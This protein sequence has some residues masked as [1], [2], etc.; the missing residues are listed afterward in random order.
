M[1]TLTSL[2]DWRGRLDAFVAETDRVFDDGGGL[3]GRRAEELLDLARHL[4][5]AN[6]L[7]F[8]VLKLAQ[9]IVL[10]GPGGRVAAASRLQT[11]ALQSKLFDGV[12]AGIAV[13]H[14]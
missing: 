10:V 11:L 2:W 14:G 8:E 12:G 5:V 1:R 9:G 6:F 7:G 13:V 3:L 4:L